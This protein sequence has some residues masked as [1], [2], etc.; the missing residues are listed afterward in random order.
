MKNPSEEAIFKT[1]AYADIFDYPLKKEEIWRWLIIN[2]NGN[3]II[4]PNK[5]EWVKT[6]GLIWRKH[7]DKFGFKDGY[8]FL[9]GR[10]KIVPLRQK[11]EI[12]SVQKLTLAQ[13]IAEGKTK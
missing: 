6:F 9:P 7:S 10:E 12:Y 13:K 11:R 5:S 4:S 3:R 8:Y 2:P 1:L